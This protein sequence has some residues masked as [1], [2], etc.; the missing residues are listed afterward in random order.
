MK[1]KISKE[2]ILKE[3]E[4]IWIEYIKNKSKD[5]YLTLYIHIPYCTQRCNYCEYFSKIIP[6]GKVPDLHIDYLEQQFK[7]AASYFKNEKIKA[8]NFGGGTPNILSPKQLERILNMIQQYW[9][10]EISIDN[11]MG[12]E[13]NPYHMSPWEFNHSMRIL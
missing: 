2:K 7:E 13:F 3:K 12:F 4:K 1:L 8:L 10:L 6:D 5:D 11:E 9:N